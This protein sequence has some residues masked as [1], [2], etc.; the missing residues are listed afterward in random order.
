MLA[1]EEERKN[2]FILANEMAFY[3]ERKEES[4]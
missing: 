4:E 2:C 3:L 1:G